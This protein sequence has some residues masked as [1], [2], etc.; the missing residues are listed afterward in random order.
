MPDELTNLL[1]FPHRT[2]LVREYRFR[3][4]VVATSLLVALVLTAG[5]LLIPTYVFLVGNINAK[6][7]H[8]ARINQTL[9]SSEDTA[10]SARLS[11]LSADADVL[12]SLA[13]RQSLSQTVSS[14][15][16]ISRAG[17]SLKG[18]AY[19]PP[20]GDTFGKVSLSGVAA[21][22]DALRGYQLTLQAA[23]FIRRAELPVS[24]YAKDTDIAFTIVLTLAP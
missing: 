8:L 18:I 10:L 1:P 9:S 7:A 2:K 15:L 6:E 24:A 14:I 22:R 21:T 16:G 4:G 17:I 11:A 20:A 19:T 13:N 3:L 23:P 12:I 5:I